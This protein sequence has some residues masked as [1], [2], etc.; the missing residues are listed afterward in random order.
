MAREITEKGL[1]KH[2]GG[3]I[4]L[5]GKG[6]PLDVGKLVQDRKEFGVDYDGKI[7]PI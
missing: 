5:Y 3:E 7:Y 4:R 6:V 2:V 1:G